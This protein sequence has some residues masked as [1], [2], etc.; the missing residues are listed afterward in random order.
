MENKT[1]Y[2]VFTSASLQSSSVQNKVIAQIKSI[3]S[4]GCKCIGLFFTTEI[5]NEIDL[6]ENIKLIPCKVSNKKLFNVIIQR[7]IINYKVIEYVEK[8]E[9]KNAVIYIRYPG[10]SYSIFKFSIKNKSN[11]ISEH[12]SKEIDEIKS[13]NAEF[14]LKFKLSN[15][16]SYIQY[17]FI[18]LFNEHIFGKFYRK[19][20]KFIVT[21]SNELA[22]YQKSKGAKNCFI[23]PNGIDVNNYKP[24][25]CI[26]LKSNINL[27][28]LKGAS[29]KS[30][31]NGIER[32][33]D[34]IDK[35]ILHTNKYNI[36]LYLCGSFNKTEIPPRDYIIE[37]G[38]LNKTELDLLFD[39]VHIGV[40]TLAQY[41]KK[42]NEVAI[43]KTREYIVRG[44]PFIYAYTDPDIKKNDLISNYC[45]NFPNNNSPIEFENI[46][47]F[48]QNVYTNINHPQI[49]NSWAIS[50]ISWN[51]KMEKLI[52]YIN[53]VSKQ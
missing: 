40:S 8:L 33:I 16:L 2:Y 19:N 11:F 27:L 46:I 43:L 49:M 7:K 38:Y 47:N 15:I 35:Y 24:R 42:F 21:E 14:P 30:D 44:L 3:N 37:T 13:F 41:K 10:A 29:S 45:L 4:V 50:N 36:K 5:E 28:F 20:T 53:L 9:K 23:N 18:P 51:I 52:K 31:W 48:A 32:I 22:I 12:I 39:K 25:I 26:D 34:S 6:M 17:Q 1:I